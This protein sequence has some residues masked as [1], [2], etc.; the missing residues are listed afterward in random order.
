VA[1]PDADR[2]GSYAGVV[3]SAS[4]PRLIVI[5]GNSGSGKT[6][7]AK[8]VRASY[9][10]GLAV[11]G[12][13]N[14]RREILRERDVPGGVNIG[15]IDTIARYSLA[16]GYHVVVEGILTASRYG[17]MLQALRRDHPA[18]SAFFYLDVSIEETLRRHQTRPLRSEV[19]GDQMR[20]WYR[21]LDLLP[22]EYETVIPEHSPLEATV[23]QVLRES[24]LAGSMTTPAG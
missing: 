3:G 1:F 6:S 21:H 7:V 18:N 13:D 17:A 2:L 11:V 16:Q 12:Q 8:A 10:R 20:E 19:S 5:R 14:V 4:P 15:L 24:G 22:H 23:R 9:G